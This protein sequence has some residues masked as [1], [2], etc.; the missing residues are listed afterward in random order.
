VKAL[1]S[2]L[3]R[4]RNGTGREERWT[5]AS[6]RFHRF[7]TRVARVSARGC[8]CIARAVS[9]TALKQPYVFRAHTGAA[10]GARARRSRVHAALPRRDRLLAQDYHS[11]ARLSCRAVRRNSATHAQPSF[12]SVRRRAPPLQ[13]C[14]WRAI[15]SMH[16][17]GLRAA[18]SAGHTHAAHTVRSSLQR[19][20]CADAHRRRGD[21]QY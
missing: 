18:E 10:C 21:A 17:T 19:Q 6:V 12:C 4:E 2:L 14:P 15:V 7:I 3:L 5:C 13:S 16:P 8:R 20:I 9:H 1:H 11:S